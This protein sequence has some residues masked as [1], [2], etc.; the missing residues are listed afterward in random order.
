[1][2]WKCVTGVVLAVVL[3]LDR[4]LFAQTSNA[5]LKRMTLQELL[6]IEVTTAGKI[7]EEAIAVPAAVHV[8]TQDDIRRS[9]ATSIPE[10]LRLA[11]GLQVARI[12]GGTWAVGIRGFADRLARS[13]LV[14]IDGRAVY[15]PLF[16][17]TYWESQDTFIGDID[18]IEIIRG[19]GGTL[20]GAN[21]VNGIINIITKKAADTPGLVATAGGGSEDRGFVAARYGATAGNVSYRAYFKALDRGPEFHAD[22]NDFDGWRSAQGGARADW[23]FDG[24]R[25]LTIQGDGYS[26]RLGE[27]PTVALYTNPF[28]ETTN[29]RAPVSGGNA[30]ARFERKSSSAGNL[31]LQTYFDRTNRD[32]IPVSEHR[33]TFDVDLQHTWTRVPRHALVWGAGFRSTSGRITAVAPTTFSPPE[34]TD[35]LYSAFVQDEFTIRPERWQLT[36]G[37]KF[38]HNDY[39]GFEVQPTARLA[40]TP[41]AAQTIWMATSRAVRT[42]SRVETDYTTTSLVNAAIPSFVRLLPNPAFSPEK[43]IAYEL[44]YR[45]RPA[46]SLFFTVSTFVNDFRD[47]LSTD[48]LPSFAESGGAQL[49]RLII[50]VTLANGMS[51]NSEGVEITGDWRI[52]SWWKA[53]G[54][55]SYLDVSA[56][57]RGGR[58][59]SQ[60]RHYED[61][62]PHHQVQ[63]TTSLDRDGWSFDWLFR[64]VSELRTPTIPAYSSSTIRLGRTLGQHFEVS[65][66]A[67]DLFETRHLEWSG[68]APIERSLYGRVTWRR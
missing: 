26:G 48:L 67:Q 56:T 68:G 7:P 5:Q 38:E 49:E 54:N 32:E 37:S 50:P 21:A 58:D 53:T 46:A 59:V 41:N 11:P 3:L 36:V 61:A 9:G 6:G 45:W 28:R 66:I 2:T 64:H 57:N 27:R 4:P 13:I 31:Q 14:L 47:V 8:I 30:L 25:S 24:G 23:T 1:M 10:I 55:Y 62:I 22:G 16:A 17:G 60:Q 29:L 20:W 34:R 33:N 19:P 65:A 52:R 42:P 40:W 15:S 35:R 39:S 12:N 43:L 51:V 18:R 63:A 44:G